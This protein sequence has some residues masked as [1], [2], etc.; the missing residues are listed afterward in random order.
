MR[1]KEVKS[2]SA[3]RA[4]RAVLEDLKDQAET[5][6]L[7]VERLEQELA[8][9]NEQRAQTETRILAARNALLVPVVEEVAGR[10]LR[11]HPAVLRDRAA[12]EM[13][14]TEAKAPDGFLSVVDRLKATRQINEPLDATRALTD[15]AQMSTPHADF[16]TRTAAAAKTRQMMDSL[17][18]DADTAIDF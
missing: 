16:E 2:T 14:T 10:L 1:G 7:V 13:L 3:A 17:L 9:L 6:R 5:Q 8:S 4:A 15:A 12:L 11:A 18:E